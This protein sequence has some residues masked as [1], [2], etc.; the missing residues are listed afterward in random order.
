MSFT[1]DAN[2]A[3][4]ATLITW[5]ICGLIYPLIM[6]IFGQ[7][8]FPAQANGSLIT[9]SRKQV[10]GSDL[11][12]QPFTS[13]RY[14]NGRPSTTNYS[15]ADPRK[16]ESGVLKTGISGASNLAPSN[17]ALIE[18]IQGKDGFQGLQTAGIKPTADLVYTSGSSLDPHISLAGAKA[19]IARVAKARGVQKQQL[20]S[21]INQNIDRRFL[22][23]FGEPG[24]NVL[25]LNL[26]VDALK[27]G[28]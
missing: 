14:F 1:R 8:V 3:I 17:I 19:Q 27:S 24:V 26:A 12:G 22:G 11:I 20:E 7:I 5:I 10:I 21:L 23:I 6:I 13:E 18:R 16:D 28:G 25:K 15:T 9:N 2:Q 4:R